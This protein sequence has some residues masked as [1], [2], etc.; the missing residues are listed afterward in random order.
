MINKIKQFQ[1]NNRIYTY[2]NMDFFLIYIIITGS[3]YMIKVFC[4]RATLHYKCGQCDITKWQKYYKHDF[5][6][7]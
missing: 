7:F 2:Y 1:F 4:A 3:K 5:N 6:K